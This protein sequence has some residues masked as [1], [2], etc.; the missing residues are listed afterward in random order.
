MN[1]A[2]IA[3]PSHTLPATPPLTLAYAA[4]VLEQHRHIVRIYDLALKP[5]APLSASLHPLR[6]FRPHTIV[7]AG[8]RLDLLDEA[9]CLLDDLKTSVV[10]IR[11][12]RGEIEIGFGWVDVFD[13]IDARSRT[14]D[15]R[16][17]LDK[18]PKAR[19][20]PGGNIDRLP[21]PARHLLSI[22]SYAQRA[23]GGEL[24]TTLL[25]GFPDEQ[26]SDGFVPR[27]PA[28]IVAEMRSVSREYGVRHYLLPG[29][30]L[31]RHRD[32]LNEL[33]GLICEANLGIGWEGCVDIDVLDEALLA[34]FAQAGCETIRLDLTA[35]RVFESH[36]TRS[37]IKRIVAIARRHD[38][39]VRAHLELEPPYEAIPHLV[40]VAATFGLDDAIF[41]IRPKASQSP[42][43]TD[44]S[45]WEAVARQLYYVGRKRQHIVD[46]FG[47]ALG[48]L[49]WKLRH[50]KLVSDV[51]SERGSSGHEDL[52]GSA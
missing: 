45:Q 39:Y 31:T 20:K 29:M 50:S 11:I 40:D 14:P 44:D 38:I 43:D 32:W 1:V 16:I 8:D 42:N 19:S 5:D 51:F 28:Q 35:S 23:V 12:S 30:S 9:I 7:V 41:S 25:A 33:L 13:W 21:F 48:A 47:P 24:Q 27:S 3:L 36:Q 2:L 49:I 10:P 18:L 46:R 37:Q 6:A 15:H 34:H 17:S 22:E 26:A 4:A 52:A